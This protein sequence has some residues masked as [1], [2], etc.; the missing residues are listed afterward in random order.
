ML[1]LGSGSGRDCYV[2]AAQVGERGSVIGVDMTPAQLE[3]ARRHAESY[4]TQVSAKQKSGRCEALGLSGWLLQ[5][6]LD[7]TPAVVSF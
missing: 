4:C 1:D 3:V 5:T 2:A 6:P 7:S